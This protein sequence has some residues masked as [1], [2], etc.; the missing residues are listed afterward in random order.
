MDQQPEARP[1]WVAPLV[2]AHLSDAQFS[3]L[4]AFVERR[5]GIRLAEGKRTM[6]EGR[7]RRRLRDLG[8]D[9][10]SDYC[11]LVLG[12]K[13][14]DEVALMI[15]EVTTNK[16]DFFREPQHFN[17]LTSHAIPT[18]QRAGQSELRC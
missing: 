6:L 8:L 17:Y 16:T 18:L 15:D 12:G 4:S 3:Q 7:L 13:A 5:C 2:G 14:E 10:F 9:N 1:A 11:A